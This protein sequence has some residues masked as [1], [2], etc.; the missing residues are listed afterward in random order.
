MAK[1]I[2]ILSDGT[3]Q[4]GGVGV[5][6]NI[7]RIFNII[8]DR[9]DEQIV[10]YD[11][12]LGTNYSKWLGLISGYGISKNIK[13]C[14]RFLF[15]NFESGD[16]IFLLGFSRGAATV[17]SLSAFIHHFGI[18][19]KSR[20]DL[21]KKA[22]QIYRTDDER[23]KERAGKFIDKHHT[24]WAKVKF[25]GCFDT[26][27]ALGVPFQGISAILD[28]IPYFQHDFHN[29]KLS[30]SVENAYQALAID[31][32]R[33]TFHPI[34][35]DAQKRSDQYIRQVWFPGM[36]TDVGGGY[37]EHALSDIPLLWMLDMA[38]SKGLLI[39]NPERVALNPD[40]NGFMHD[41]RG[42]WWQKLYRKERRS[43]PE[44]RP[45]KPVIHQSVLNRSKN[46]DNETHPHYH[47]WILDLNY[48]IEPWDA[49]KE[50]VEQV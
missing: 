4:E 43:W 18:L 47:P 23:L 29:F 1:N 5:N 48:E 24:M 50:T 34:L 20:P 10:Y 37:L 14:Y 35:W 21:I 44:D 30:E 12:G 27:A 16:Q 40:A 9:T 2:I 33:K 45:D 26:V 7:Y 8:E 46:T 11:P 25:L 31:D 15:E 3:G 19:P 17:R 28:Q 41:S 13:D 49:K 38:A 22:Y 42:K 39:H 6:S 36:H 32:Q